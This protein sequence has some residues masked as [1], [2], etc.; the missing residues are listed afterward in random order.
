MTATTT[1]T[2]SST[3][4]KPRRRTVVKVLSASALTLGIAAVSGYVWLDQTSDVRNQGVTECTD[5]T[6]DGGTA[7]DAQGVCATLAELNAA[8]AQGDADA[9]GALFTEN[10]TY[11]TFTGT[12]YE[13]RRDITESHRALF[14]GVLKGS[15]LADSYL[16]IR[17]FG[18]DT[19][20]VTTR[21]DRYDDERP[22]KLSKTATFTMVREQDGQW[23]I[24]AFQNTQ[25]KSVMERISFL[26]EPDTKPEAEQ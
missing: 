18:A 3:P 17:L 14:N 8:W 23:R 9:Y 12:H 24:A 11:T 5:V 4:A 20:V 25:R 7:A 21:G 13:G 16:G 2:E 6:P 22:S 15:K 10:G 19:A 26:F 1:N